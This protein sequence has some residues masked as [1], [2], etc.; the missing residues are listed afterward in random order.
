MTDSVQSFYNRDPESEWCR[1]GA[2]LQR[3]ELESTLRLI[4]DHFPG[5]G[6]ICDIGSGPGRY[7]IEL[8][9]WG[10]SVT[11]VDLAG[12]ALLRARDEF[13]AAGLCAE[14]FLE[15]DARDLATLE[16]GTFD[17]ALMLG[18]LY[19][20]PNADD[21]ALALA[22]LF[23]ILRPGASA[24]VAY[25]NSWGIL[26]TGITDFPGWYRTIDTARSLLTERAYS[27]EELQG[28]T[29]AY[30]STPPHALREVEAAGFESITYYGVEGFC[31]G[32]APA[33]AALAERDPIAYEN[34]VTL[35]VETAGLPQY[36]DATDHLHIV[37]RR[38]D[39]L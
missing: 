15:A 33:V 24:I 8:A 6:R 2:P 4:R 34:I 29:A 3:I 7:S 13:T 32:M 18:P 5:Q 23:R 37:L 30:W 11:L 27:S 31:G 39:S 19:H 38:P 25:L 36:R 20:L 22:E 14:R 9:K 10:Y 1:L 28:F 26:R 35:A 21:R 16:T 17:A 12:N